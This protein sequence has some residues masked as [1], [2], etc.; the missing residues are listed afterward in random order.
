[1]KFFLLGNYRSY[2]LSGSFCS[3]R[4]GYSMEESG[5]SF[6]LFFILLGYHPS[7]TSVFSIFFVLFH[8]YSNLGV[9]R[10]G[11][12]AGYFLRFPCVDLFLVAL[13]VQPLTTSLRSPSTSSPQ[14]QIA[15]SLLSDPS[16]GRTTE[17]LIIK[18]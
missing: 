5:L 2:F 7:L 12:L 9:P 11:R 13:V 4:F 17:K 1:M 18:L 3:S 16:K 14:S 10:P 6:S 8:P 15:G